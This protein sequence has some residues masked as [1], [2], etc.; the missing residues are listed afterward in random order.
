MSENF[1]LI[2]FGVGIFIAGWGWGQWLSERCIRIENARLFKGRLNISMPMD[3]GTNVQLM[4]LLTDI[5]DKAEQMT[6]NQTPSFDNKESL[7]KN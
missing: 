1:Q 3:H 4:S 2:I 6:A 7:Q 5:I